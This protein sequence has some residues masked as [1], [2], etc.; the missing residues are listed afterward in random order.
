MRHFEFFALI[1]SFEEFSDC[2]PKFV[3]FTT[4]SL[5]RYLSALELPLEMIELRKRCTADDC[6][7]VSGE[8]GGCTDSGEDYIND[9]GTWESLQN[10]VSFP[11]EVGDLQILSLG[12]FSIY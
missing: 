12:K 6:N 10:T 5:I 2:C 8:D 9:K 4:V 1:L 7:N 11:Y 3:G